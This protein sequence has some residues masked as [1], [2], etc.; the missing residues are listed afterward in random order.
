MVHV[1]TERFSEK[2][3]LLRSSWQTV[4]IGDI[5]H[6]PGVLSLLEKHLSGVDIILWAGCIDRGVREMLAARFPKLTIVQGKVDDEGKASSV[7]LADAIERADILVHGSGPSVVA[8]DDVQAWMRITSK[9]F[10]IYGVTIDPL[11]IPGVPEV[12]MVLKKQYEAVL[13]LPQGHLADDLRE[14]LERAEFVYCRDRMSLD[15]L[16]SQGVANPALEFGPDGAFG[17][18]LRDDERA[19][20]FLTE[21][22][23]KDREFIC[24]I[25]RLR[26]TPYH[27]T[28]DVPGTEVDEM[29]AEISERYQESDFVKIREFIVRCV[30]ETGLK[31]LL[32][33]EMTYQVEIGLKLCGDYLPEDVRDRVIWRP[34]YWLPDEACSTYARS[35][36]VVSMDNHSPI[37][38][39]ALGVPTIFVRQPSDTTKGQMWHDLGMSNWFFEIDEMTGDQLAEC[40]LDIYRDREGACEQVER[41]MAEVR[42]IQSTSMEKVAQI[43]TGTQCA[44][45]IGGVSPT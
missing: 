40:F 11:A 35:F 6:S 9:P 23:L 39:L 8:L 3:V 29:R 17:I 22:E 20:A 12:G 28:H 19:D 2:T 27:L 26:F 34:N 36:A 15:Y 5:G 25:P 10:G 7:E 38:A 32:C 14:V 21:H 41:I 1:K 45:F 18:D 43:L 37:F 4:N 13:A 33:P 42:Q 24:L 31:V 44:D 30:R 16:K